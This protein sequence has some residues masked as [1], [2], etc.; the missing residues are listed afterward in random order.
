MKKL[1]S[2]ARSC[3]RAEEKVTEPFRIE[4]ILAG[5]QCTAEYIAELTKELATLAN[6]VGLTK[7]ARLLASAQL[8]AELWLQQGG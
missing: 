6:G 1:A 5:A 3:V 8:E 7:L 4:E 2:S